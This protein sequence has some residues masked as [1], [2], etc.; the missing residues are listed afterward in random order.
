MI[1]YMLLADKKEKKGR[2]T[3]RTLGDVATERNLREDTRFGAAMIS[4][5]FQQVDGL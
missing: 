2:H 1:E 4:C 5:F 3:R